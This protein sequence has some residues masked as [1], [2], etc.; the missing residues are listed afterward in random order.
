MSIKRTE[1][2]TAAAGVIGIV[3]FVTMITFTNL[4]KYR[5]RMREIE[6]RMVALEC[7]MNPE[8]C[9]AIVRHER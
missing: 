6:I 8:I 2:W 1:L 5:D 3:G 4:M 9:R 7:S